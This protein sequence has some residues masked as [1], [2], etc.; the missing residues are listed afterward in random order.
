MMNWVSFL[1]LINSIFITEEQG[2]GRIKQVTTKY[3]T[4]SNIFSVKKGK[5]H[6]TFM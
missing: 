4:P 6:G 2:Q 3:P 5:R 1:I